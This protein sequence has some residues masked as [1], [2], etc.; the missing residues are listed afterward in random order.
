MSDTGE[1]DV[2]HEIATADKRYRL[3]GKREYMREYL[4]DQDDAAEEA[5]DSMS[6]RYRLGKRQDADELGADEEEDDEEDSNE[7]SNSLKE[8]RYR[9]MGKR[10]RLMGKRYRLMGKRGLDLE[11]HLQ[12]RYRLMGF[13]FCFFVGKIFLII[14]IVQ[15]LKASDIDLKEEANKSLRNAT[16]WASHFF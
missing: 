6:K 14:F 11:D 1:H 2:E 8:K 4:K 12:K 15:M 3:H 10:Y 7:E 13:K 5:R 9:L 16:D